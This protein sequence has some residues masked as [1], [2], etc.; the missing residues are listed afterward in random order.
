MI[1][2]VGI[3]ANKSL[4][5]LPKQT[6]WK[7]PTLILRIWSLV[8]L[9]SWF[10]CLPGGHGPCKTGTE[11]ER[12]VGEAR[13]INCFMVLLFSSSSII[14][15]VE[16]GSFSQTSRFMGLARFWLTRNL[17]NC[18]AKLKTMI[19][20]VCVDGGDEDDH[21]HAHGMI[22]VYGFASLVILSQI[23]TT[24]QLKSNGLVA[25]WVTLKSKI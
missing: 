22:W 23:L 20:Y 12:E 6:T 14:S 5:L 2:N 9:L 10:E 7:T 18:H 13:K 25:T 8:W 15:T 19:C 3:E 16:L 21:V 4:Y 17:P 11:R 24:A 1:K